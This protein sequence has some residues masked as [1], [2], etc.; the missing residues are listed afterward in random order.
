MVKEIKTERLILKSIKRTMKGF[1]VLSLLV[2]QQEINLDE[3]FKEVEW[4]ELV[5]ASTVELYEVDNITAVAGTRGEE[6]ENEILKY[7]YY[8]QSAKKRSNS[9]KLAQ[10]QQ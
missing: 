2:A 7:L 5:E 4:K 3:V 1:L 8:L 9:L 6:A 10:K